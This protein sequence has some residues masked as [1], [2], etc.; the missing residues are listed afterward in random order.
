MATNTRFWYPTFYRLV[1]KLN[2]FMDNHQQELVAFN[3]ITGDQLTELNALG[4]ALQAIVK[5]PGFPKYR[6][7][8]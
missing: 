6:E 1:R 7:T 8:R 2:R 5:D 3:Q 4:T